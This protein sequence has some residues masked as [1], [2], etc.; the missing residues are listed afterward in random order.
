[1]STLIP[2]PKTSFWLLLTILL[3][4]TCFAG[5]GRNVALAQTQPQWS[6]PQRLP[7]FEDL[8][9]Y[10]TQIGPPKLLPRPDGVV[11][12]FGSQWVGEEMAIIYSEWSLANSWTA[13]VDIILPPV[14]LRAAIKDVFLDDSGTV[15]L[16]FYAGS[17]FEGN[18][19]YSTA[20]IYE[21]V[22]RAQAWTRPVVVAPDAV[23]PG[24]AILGGDGEEELVLV[25]TGAP[26][27]QG[28]F[29]V[30]STDRGDTWSRPEPLFLTYGET[31]F[32]GMYTAV[33]DGQDQFHVLWSVGGEDGNSEALY[34]ARYQAP[35][36]EWAE[37][38]EFAR[39]IEFE[40]DTAR[41]IEYDGRLIVI[42]HNDFPTTRWMRVSEDG[43]RSWTEPVRLFE[44]VGSNGPVSFAVDSAQRLHLFFGNRVGSPTRHGMWHT[45]WQGEE[46]RAPA[47]VVSGSRVV[48]E[49][50]GVGFDPSFAESVI[51]DGNVA[52]VTWVTDPGAGPNGVWYAYA[53]LDAPETTA[54]LPTPTPA[55]FSGD[56]TAEDGAGP[57]TQTEARTFAESAPPEYQNPGMG[58]WLGAVLA[59]FIVF[60]VA[61]GFHIRSV[62]L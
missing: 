1:M 41:I 8:P 18:I 33:W 19:Y 30:H 10:E 56:T 21:D 61:V 9:Q 3:L 35:R 32:P 5:S 20:S 45:V 52:L 49:R 12:A 50:G 34:Y 58:V 54:V 55:P 11:M 22:G 29:A 42:Y 2:F 57:V 4:A 6:Q 17:G 27:E 40:A 23:A 44:H 60:V 62:Y 46:W 7:G 25:Y 37:V 47:A 39:A 13:S 16:I 28:V 51:V 36:H 26:V 43:G 31:L 53:V 14:G 38:S 48:D 24:S 15:H 59:L